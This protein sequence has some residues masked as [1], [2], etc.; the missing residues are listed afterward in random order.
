MIFALSKIIWLAL[1]PLNLILFS[2]LF[3]FLFKLVGIKFLTRLFYS[4]SILILTVSTLMP[5]GSYLNYL[6]EKNYHF[7]NY[8]PDKVDGILILGGA[9]NPFL[10]KE[11]DMVNLNGSAERLYESINLIKKFPDSKV[12][13]SGGSGSLKF[14]KLNHSDDVKI[15]FKNMG[16]DINKIYFEKKSRNTYE[17]ILFAKKLINPKA[18]EKWV[19]VTSASHLNR[20]IYIGEKLEWPLIPYAVDFNNSKKFTWSLHFNFV[21]NLVEFNSAT[22]EWLGLVSYYLMGRSSRII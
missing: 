18:G 21:K 13:F 17:N 8:Y 6:L 5:T 16:I 3:G 19:I 14:P 9:T 20:S 1:S 2:F 11:Y 22:H 10:T 7:T 4:F 12:V 15:L